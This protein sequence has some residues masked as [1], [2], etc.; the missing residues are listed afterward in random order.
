MQPSNE[1]SVSL[2]ALARTTNHHGNPLPT[3]Q[4][5][6]LH[7]ARV[8]SV[9]HA[10]GHPYPLCSSFFSPWMS[11]TRRRLRDGVG[12]GQLPRIRQADLVAPEIL[13]VSL[14]QPCQGWSVTPSWSLPTGDP[15]LNSAGHLVF[16]APPSTLSHWPRAEELAVPVHAKQR[17]EPR[18]PS[19][20][21]RQSFTRST[22]VPAPP[23]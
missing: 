7:Y 4:N 6:E 17:R 23:H 2:Y 5:R 3:S 21:V 8:D 9:E 16:D 1:V 14:R 19:R 22:R 20:L 11:K 13:L 12:A 10:I 18:R 15:A